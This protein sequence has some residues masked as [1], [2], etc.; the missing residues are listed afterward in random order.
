MCLERWECELGEDVAER[1]RMNDYPMCRG[2]GGKTY[3][4]LFDRQI[5]VLSW[6]SMVINSMMINGR[7]QH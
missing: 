3:G 7:T 2:R 5:H 4:C 1:I 6:T